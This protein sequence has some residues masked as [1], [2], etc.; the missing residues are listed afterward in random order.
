MLENT[1]YIQYGMHTKISKE[2]P[3]IKIDILSHG[4]GLEKANNIFVQR[5]TVEKI[6]LGENK[7]MMDNCIQVLFVRY[8]KTSVTKKA[9]LLTKNNNISF[10]KELI[11]PV[12][13]SRSGLFLPGA[14]AD[15]I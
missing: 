14:A 6:F 4:P 13:R 12:F 1:D 9:N 2:N 11:I 7:F 15:P 3:E 10:E 8:L 5:F